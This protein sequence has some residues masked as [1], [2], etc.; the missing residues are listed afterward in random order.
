VKKHS[1]IDLSEV[2]RK[3]NEE[4]LEKLEESET[5]MSSE[6]LIEELLKIV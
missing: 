5:A 2:V 6:R 4:H 3:A 1:E